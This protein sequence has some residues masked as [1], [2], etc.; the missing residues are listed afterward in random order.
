MLKINSKRRRTTAEVQ[1]EKRLKEAAEAENANKVQ[2]F[3]T[4]EQQLK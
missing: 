2:Q 1:E 4:M 3:N